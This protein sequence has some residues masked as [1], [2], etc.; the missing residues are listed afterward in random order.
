MALEGLAGTNR[1]SVG[2][3]VKND[4]SDVTP[5][6]LLGLRIQKTQGTECEPFSGEMNFGGEHV[7]NL[8]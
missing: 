4:A 2:V 5:I 1:L 6:G 8:D 7:L 3:D